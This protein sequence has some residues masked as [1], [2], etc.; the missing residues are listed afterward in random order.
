MLDEQ[1]IQKRPTPL[2]GGRRGLDGM[3]SRSRAEPRSGDLIN[4]PSN[5]RRKSRS[6]ARLS[7]QA[8]RAKEHPA[9]PVARAG[10]VE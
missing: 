3:A 4:T 5:E 6:L 7:R 8:G 9:V 2:H 1:G 10:W